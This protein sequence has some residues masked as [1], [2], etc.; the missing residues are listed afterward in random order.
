M[1]I[2][3]NK[4]IVSALTLGLLT[5]SN[6]TDAFAEKMTQLFQLHLVKIYNK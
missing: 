5:S 6:P 1:E 4:I 2:R 3:K